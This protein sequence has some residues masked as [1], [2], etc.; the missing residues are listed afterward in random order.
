MCHCPL[1]AR[2]CIISN[3]SQKILVCLLITLDVMLTRPRHIIL[4]MCFRAHF[5]NL[6]WPKYLEIHR[7]YFNSTT[8][9][10][11]ISMLYLLY[12]LDIPI[13]RTLSIT[14][15]VKAFTIDKVSSAIVYLDC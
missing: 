3:R 1:A 14:S 11:F 13:K 15:L 10:L 12:F 2:C 4:V 6:R 5:P 8:Y 9:T 7:I